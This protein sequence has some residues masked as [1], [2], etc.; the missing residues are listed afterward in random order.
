MLT[1]VKIV[2]I[3]D[4]IKKPVSLVEQI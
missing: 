1:S 3:L 2:I 4:H